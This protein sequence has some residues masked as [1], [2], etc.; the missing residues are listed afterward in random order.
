MQ[1]LCSSVRATWWSELVATTR[2]W[3]GCERVGRI[4]VAGAQSDYCIRTTTQR[5]AA[6][7]FHV[8]LASDCHTTVDA[9]FDGQSISAA[10]IVAHTNMYFGGLR[11]ATQRIGI[12]R[13]DDPMI[14]RGDVARVDDGESAT[15]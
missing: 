8:V 14:F 10:Q 6:E 11:Y 4:V 9:T 13:H 2:S 1:R 3:C 7:G 15:R 5:A 12:A